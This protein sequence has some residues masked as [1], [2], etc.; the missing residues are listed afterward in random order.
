[1]CDVRSSYNVSERT[2]TATHVNEDPMIG[3]ILFVVG[4]GGHLA[5]FHLFHQ[6]LMAGPIDFVF[7]YCDIDKVDSSRLF[8]SH[9]L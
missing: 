1:M 8:F 9:I 4:W 7:V 2:N 3:L 6:Q 5:C